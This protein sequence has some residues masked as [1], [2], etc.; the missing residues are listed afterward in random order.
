M[1]IVWESPVPIE[2]ALAEAL[3]VFLYH[4]KGK[5]DYS[6]RSILQPSVKLELKDLED[7]PE[8]NT[9]VVWWVHVK[10]EYEKLK[11]EMEGIDCK[12][13]RS[14][15]VWM[16]SVMFFGKHMPKILHKLTDELTKEEVEATREEL[17]KLI[18]FETYAYQKHELRL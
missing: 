10:R 11:K 13:G 4:I 9:L 8:G 12:A 7:T 18:G 17:K 3:S 5:L 16:P 15:P 6:E 1:P 14:C 2:P